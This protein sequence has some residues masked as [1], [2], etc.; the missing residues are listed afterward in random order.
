[1]DD[2]QLL[3]DET[4]RL[5]SQG[6]MRPTILVMPDAPWLGRAG[7]YVDSAYRGPDDHGCAVEAALTGDLVTHVDETFRTLPRREDRIVGGF[8]MGGAGALRFALAHQATFSAAIVLSP[9]VYVPRPPTT[10]TCR[11]SGAFGIGPKR[12]VQ[13]RYAALGYPALLPDIDPRLPLRIFLAAGDREYTGYPPGQADL[14]IPYQTALL[15][16][17]LV[18]SGISA[19]LRIL[20]GGHGWDVWLP[21]FVEAFEMFL[22][23]DG[24]KKLP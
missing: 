8:S 18:Q 19:A 5:V 1:M 21:A 6:R 13:E 4:D 24:G 20:D 15:H 23:T 22:P 7:W 9:A 10:S 14:T 3:V 11:Q 16:N 17:Q 12:F 2:W